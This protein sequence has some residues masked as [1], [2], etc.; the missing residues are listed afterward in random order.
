MMPIQDF[1]KTTKKFFQETPAKAQQ[2]YEE[3]Q[4]TGDIG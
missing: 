4:K 1:I 3:Q 2:E